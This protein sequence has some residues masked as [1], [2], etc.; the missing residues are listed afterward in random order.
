MGKL[1]ILLSLCLLGSALAG[2]TPE[3]PAVR[4]IRMTAKKYEYN[5]NEVRVQQ[6]ERVRLVLKALDRTHGFEIKEYGIKTELKEG[7][8]TVVEFTADQAGSFQFKCSKWCGFGH[9][10]MRG[11]LIVEP[12]GGQEKPQ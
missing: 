9:G 10:K 11:T 4:E 1:A 5:P 12:S 7:E 6:G 8:D 2:E 3:E